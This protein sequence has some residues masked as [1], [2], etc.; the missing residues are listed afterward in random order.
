MLKVR[1]RTQPL[2]PSGELR[3]YQRFVEA[4]FTGRG[5][6]LS[7]IVRNVTG[8]RVRNLP[9]LPRDLSAESWAWLYAE[10]SRT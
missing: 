7:E 4:V 8:W 6:G 3:H 9:A 5:R 10:T 1:R 2:V